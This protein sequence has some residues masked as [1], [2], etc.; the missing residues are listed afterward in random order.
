MMMKNIVKLLLCVSLVVTLFSSCDKDDDY[1]DFLDET[2]WVC[3]RNLLYFHNGK[4]EHYILDENN[5]AMRILEI[6]DYYKV[7]S[8]KQALLKVNGYK[9][10]DKLYYYTDYVEYSSSC[11]SRSPRS[12]HYYFD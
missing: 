11:F 12:K 6:F 1:A 3:N 7:V 10:P 8:D 4:G 5:K 2:V 9:N